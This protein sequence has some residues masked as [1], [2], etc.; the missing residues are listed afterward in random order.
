MAGRLAGLHAERQ[1]RLREAARHQLAQIW[2]ALPGHDRA[3]LDQWLAEALPVVQ[4]AEQQAVA[5]INAYVALSLERQPLPLDLSELT[6]AAVRRGTPPEEVYA[7]PFVT[8]WSQLGQGKEWEAASKIALERIERSVAMDAQLSMRAAS[9][10]IDAADPNLYGYRR[11]ANASACKFCRE[12]DGAYVK[13]TSG[14]AMALHSGCGCSL[15][16]N[17]EPH[18][19]AHYLPDGTEI[20]PYAYG[21][22]NDS[23][24]IREH[25][26]Y[27]PVLVDPQQ[28]FMTE[29]EAL[30][31]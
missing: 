1:R 28:H 27:G 16:V 25:G 6:G 13:G 30:A 14:F 18:E 8:L 3:N 29:A 4:G 31:R 15:E 26:E 2:E 5:L 17:K 22:L 24:A 11:R 21:P 19:G 10:A 12:V 9:D 20:R 7:R 23:V